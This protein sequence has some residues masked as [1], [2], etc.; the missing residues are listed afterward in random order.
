[1]AWGEELENLGGPGHRHNYV[2]EVQRPFL[3]FELISRSSQGESGT[4]YLWNM[5][6]VQ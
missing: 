5:V 6:N 1:M 2:H 3:G 4:N